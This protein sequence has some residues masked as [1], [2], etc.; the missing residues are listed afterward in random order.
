MTYHPVAMPLPNRIAR[1]ADETRTLRRDSA[2]APRPPMNGLF[3]LPEAIQRN[4]A[5]DAWLASQAPELGAIA[6]RWFV[7]MRECGSDVREVM[8]DGCPT[9]CVQDAAFAHV[10]VYTAHVNV[11]FFHGAD[12]EDP[13][14]LLQGSGKRMRHVK[15]KPR[16]D[17]EARALDA[18]VGAAYADVKRRLAMAQGVGNPTSLRKRKAR[19]RRATR[20]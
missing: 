18:L 11:G 19:A 14:G 8:H 17:L 7:R 13:A 20:G 4:P 15:V 3:R 10:G 16:V 9:A 5:I 12:L 2:R 6:R 1:P